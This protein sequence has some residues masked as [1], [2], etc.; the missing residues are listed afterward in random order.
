[1][2]IAWGLRGTQYRYSHRLFPRQRVRL[3]DRAGQ[4]PGGPGGADPAARQDII[5]V[6]S[7]EL[8]GSAS[9]LRA[10]ADPGP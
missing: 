10:P 9:A 7:P 1:M 4:A 5:G 8:R 3:S 6:A 2:K